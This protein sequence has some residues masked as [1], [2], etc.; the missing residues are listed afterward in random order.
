MGARVE[1]PALARG[2]LTPV[3]PGRGPGAS[4]PEQGLSG[5]DPFDPEFCRALERKVL[6]PIIRDYFRARVLGA[7]RLPKRGPVILAANHSGNAF[8]HD[9]IVLD[10][11]LWHR[12]GL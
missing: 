8:P 2:G 9:G 5:R 3:A 12:D 4:P 6:G 7:E 1:V 11:A 10:A